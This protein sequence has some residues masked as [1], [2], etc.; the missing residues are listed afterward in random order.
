VQP[1]IFI[2]VTD[3]G[4]NNAKIGKNKSKLAEFGPIWSIWMKF[5]QNRWRIKLR[6]F[7]R[8]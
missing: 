3:F 1:V 4:P 6:A 2:S 7:D 8:F 5:G